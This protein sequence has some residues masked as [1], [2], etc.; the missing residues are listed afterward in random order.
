M[1]V[2]EQGHAAFLYIYK[3]IYI[4][5]DVYLGMSRSIV[6]HQVY[7]LIVQHSTTQMKDGRMT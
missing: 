6:S 3:Y 2:A 4:Y 5:V 1:P 7:G